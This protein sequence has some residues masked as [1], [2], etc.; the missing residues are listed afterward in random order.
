[1]AS[2]NLFA[3][4]VTRT[5]W[6]LPFVH[7]EIVRSVKRLE[8]LEKSMDPDQM[9]RFYQQQYMLATHG[10]SKGAVDFSKTPGVITTN[11]RA[12]QIM[13]EFVGKIFRVHCGN[14]YQVV[15]V[16]DLMVGHKLGEFAPTRVIK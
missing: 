16:T 2:G 5:T 15:R 7:P 1:M 14:R 11:S 9:K 10:K 3:K 13:P 12:S 4:A 8:D 6:R